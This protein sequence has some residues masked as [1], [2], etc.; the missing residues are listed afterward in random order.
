MEAAEALGERMDSEGGSTLSE[1]VAY[2]YR[3]CMNKSISPE[4]EKVLV[5]LYSESY[6]EWLENEG[7]EI[8]H[9]ES[10]ALVANVLLNLD[11]VLNN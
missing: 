8:G 1:K 9:K 5:D 7:P 4:K 10:L 11:E 2:G 3:L 6:D